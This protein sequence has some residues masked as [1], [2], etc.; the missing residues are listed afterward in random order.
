MSRRLFMLDTNTVSYLTKSKSK[1]VYERLLGLRPGED[2]CVSAVTEGE[3]WY[4]LELVG[5]GMERRKRLA[6]LL[7]RLN[8]LPWDRRESA[9]YG[10]FRARQ[11][12]MGRPLAPLDTMIAAHAISAG[13]ILVSSDIAFT[14][15]TGLPGLENWATDL[16]PGV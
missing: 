10:A 15:A 12:R 6:A 14:H 13:A 16:F 8:V 4:G 7:D 9:V 5:A 1:A 3:L 11:Q 2:S